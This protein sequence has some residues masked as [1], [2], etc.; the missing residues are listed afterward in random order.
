MEFGVGEN[1]TSDFVPL[2]KK[3]LAAP[4]ASCPEISPVALKPWIRLCILLR[5]LDIRNVQ[6]SAKL[7]YK[8]KLGSAGI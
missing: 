5:N 7:F 2:Y 4:L 8:E 6:I 3:F 1:S